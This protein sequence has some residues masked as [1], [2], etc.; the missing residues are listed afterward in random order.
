MRI[1]R[2][3]V[4]TDLHHARQHVLNN[5]ERPVQA[6]KLKTAFGLNVALGFLGH[7]GHGASNISVSLPRADSQLG[8]D[9]SYR[10]PAHS[11]ANRFGP[12]SR[13]AVFVG[14]CHVQLPWAFSL[15]PVGLAATRR[16]IRAALQCR[17]ASR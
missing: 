10:F 6:V 4:F 14:G 11:K 1:V 16:S 15:W 2:V 5:P 8:R 9:L 12:A 17:R 7:L 3:L 13:D